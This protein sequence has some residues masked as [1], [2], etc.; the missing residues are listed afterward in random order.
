[1]NI[2][3]FLSLAIM[4]AALI[5]FF[6]LI[7]KKLK[8]RKQIINTDGFRM[9]CPKCDTILME[10][11]FPSETIIFFT[12]KLAWGDRICKIKKKLREGEYWLHCYNC[13]QELIFDADK[14]REMFKGDI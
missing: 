6:T 1:M 5:A 2:R 9:L 3:F 8:N 7:E 14:L 11:F 12:K 10:V 13:D 4:F